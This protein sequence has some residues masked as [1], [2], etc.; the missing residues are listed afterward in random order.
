[1]LSLLVVL[2][3]LINT[4]RIVIQLSAHAGRYWDDL[5]CQWG[6]HYVYCLYCELFRKGALYWYVIQIL[7]SVLFQFHGFRPVAFC[8]WLS[9]CG[10]R[11]LVFFGIK[12]VETF[13]FFF[14][15]TYGETLRTSW[16][17][18]V[19]LRTAVGDEH[20]VPLMS[21]VTLCPRR[22]RVDVKQAA[23]PRRPV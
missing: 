16:S 20:R 8:T 10:F 17:F 15:T 19:V 9:A 14:R 23:L 3:N 22:K 7:I 6:S 5:V 11:P 1:M 4:C 12:P 2:I 13:E 21:S 18:R